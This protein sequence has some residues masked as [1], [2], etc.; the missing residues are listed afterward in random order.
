MPFILIKNNLKLMLRSKWILVLMTILP[1]ITIVLLSNAFKDMMDTAYKIEPFEVGYHLS[2]GSAYKDMIPQLKTIC[3]DNNIILQEYQNEDATALLKRETVAVFVEITDDSY[4]IY[5]SDDKKTEAAVTESILSTFF[6]QA[7]DAMVGMA[8][9]AQNGLVEL[10]STSSV[11]VNH[12]VLA[13]DPVPSSTDYYGII[14]IIY[15]AWCGMISLSA[16]IT[17]ERKS[18]ISK[19]MRISHMSKVSYYIGKLIPCAIATF[20]ESCIAWIISVVLLDIHWGKIWACIGIMILI[21]LAASTFGMVLFQLFKNAAVS[22][23]A[24]FIII[25]I[26]GLWG[27]SFQTYIYANIPQRIVNISPLYYIN[28][29]VVEF[30]TKGYSDYAGRCILYLVSIIVICGIAGILMMDREMGESA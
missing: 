26:A 13:T 12:E 5:Q 17:S 22:I 24:G 21:S 2:D 23:V 6:Y 1:V 8:Y 28:R 10:P 18:A 11:K 4:V 14:Y 19:R 16:V 29:T 3:K 15:F 7:Y 20:L 30:S 25:W 9:Q 27:G